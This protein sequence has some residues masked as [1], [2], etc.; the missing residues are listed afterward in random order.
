MLLPLW[1]VFALVLTNI[2]PILLLLLCLPQF[3]L[4]HCPFPYHDFFVPMLS[5]S[6]EKLFAFLAI[7]FWNSW[8]FSFTS[9]WCILHLSVLFPNVFCI[10]LYYFLPRLVWITV[11]CLMSGHILG[12][13]IRRGGRNHG[14]SNVVE[15]KINV[16][17]SLAGKWNMRRQKIY[18]TPE[19]NIIK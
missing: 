1:L 7:S 19:Y 9:N 3:S 11:V 8:C 17:T 14:L 2:A 15:R 13:V 12:S 18:N 4:L 10:Y 16:P 5:N 6:P